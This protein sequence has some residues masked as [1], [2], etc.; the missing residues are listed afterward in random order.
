[1]IDLHAADHARPRGLAA[2]LEPSTV[3]RVTRDVAVGAATLG[4]IA[5]L[6]GPAAA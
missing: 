2:A 6:D 5:R 4:A 3:R 1:M